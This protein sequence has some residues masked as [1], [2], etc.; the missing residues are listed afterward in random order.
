MSKNK[1]SSNNLLNSDPKTSQD[2]KYNWHEDPYG[3]YSLAKLIE[4][5]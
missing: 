5:P 4:M 3:Y 1:L 2:I